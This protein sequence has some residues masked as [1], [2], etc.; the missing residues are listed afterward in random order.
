MRLEG[1]GRGILHYVKGAFF[2]ATTGG[3]VLG[4]AFAGLL[5]LAG[6]AWLVYA[7]SWWL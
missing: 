2:W 5:A 1:D 6:V 4:L 3:L 7:L